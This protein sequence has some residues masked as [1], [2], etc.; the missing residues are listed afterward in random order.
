M[1]KGNLTVAK[2]HGYASYDLNTEKKRWEH[3]LDKN[4]HK[5]KCSNYWSTGNAVKGSD[6]L[7]G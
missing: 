7:D 5:D 1:F 4:L 3:N 2:G 6:S